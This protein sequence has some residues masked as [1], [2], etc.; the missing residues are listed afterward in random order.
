MM[1]GASDQHVVVPPPQRV[2]RLLRPPR[3]LTVLAAPGGFGKTSALEWWAKHWPSP[4]LWADVAGPDASDA[5]MARAIVAALRIRSEGPTEGAVDSSGAALA[6]CNAVVPGRHVSIV[7]DDVSLGG[8]RFAAELSETFAS[9]RRPELAVVV[10]GRMRG[11][12]SSLPSVAQ[13]RALWIGPA[14]LRL[15]AGE[16]RRSL[17]RL[18]ER[19][20]TEVE[21]ARVMAIT[22]GWPGGLVMA[23]SILRNGRPDLLEAVERGDLVLGRATISAL[24]RDAIRAAAA[25]QG[26]PEAWLD[27][28]A[29]DGLRV[30]LAELAISG[31][32]GRARISG[33]R[34]S[35]GRFRWQLTSFAS[36]AIAAWLDWAHPRDAETLG[37]RGSHGAG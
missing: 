22:D 23:S 26:D 32:V 34:S 8:L 11:P 30:G 15:R 27:E 10:A 19:P 28:S 18:L 4:V 13:S 31:L 16:V 2:L 35:S 9:L 14:E 1:D 20:A 37:A 7:L 5:E 21:V 33:R 29:S 6:V 3:A 36:E 17:E 12:L 24:S 25:L